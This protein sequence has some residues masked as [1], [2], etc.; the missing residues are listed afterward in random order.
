MNFVFEDVSSHRNFIDNWELN[1]IGAYRFTVCPLFNRMNVIRFAFRDL[2]PD[3]EILDIKDKPENYIIPIGVNNDPHWWAGGEFSSNPN[4]VSFFEFLN[5]IYL[6]DLVNGGAF[7]LI[8][9]SFEGYH[10]DWVFNFFHKECEKRNIPANK[11]IFVTGNSI[12][13]QRYEEWLK[14]NPKEI[15]MN[16]LPYSHFENDVFLTSQQMLQNNDLP[17]FE[18]QLLY[19]KNNIQSIKLYN[20]LNKKPREH[21][22]WFYSRLFYNNLLD[23]GL[24][25]MNKIPISQRLYCGEFMEHQSVERFANTLPS[26]IYGISNEIEDT[27]FYINRINHQV[28]DDS[29]I[30]II[31]EARFEDEEGT[32]FLSEKVFKPITCHHPFIVMG[33]KH[34]LKELKKLGYKTFSNWIDE[35]YDELDNLQRMDAII[36]VLNDIDKIENK[37]EWFKSMEEVLKHNYEILRRNVTKKY[38]YAYNKIIEICSNTKKII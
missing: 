10:S 20:N 2:N 22:I 30:S 33:N 36:K 14:T 29:W 11:I 3:M 1:G 32:V 38:P 13:E 18:E 24:V 34:S 7:L 9:S 8:D 4:V 27:G 26:L 21:R 23:K 31:S 17:T 28:C 5:E 16:P 6:N 25:S 37:F 15:E 19:K 35:S 12:V